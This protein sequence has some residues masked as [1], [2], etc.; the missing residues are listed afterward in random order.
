M[1]SVIFKIALQEATHQLSSLA[2]QPLLEAQILLAHVLQQSR[3][4]LHAWPER[5][6]TEAQLNEYQSVILRRVAGEPIAYIIGERE[7]W[8]LPLSVT[9]DTLIP[10]PE[11][12]L[13]VEFV[14]Q[15]VVE[16][17]AVV[18]DLGTGSGAI[19]LA[20]A[21]E[22]PAW[23]IYAIDCSDKALQV[24]SFNAQQ[25]GLNN[26]SFLLSN[27]CT[28]LPHLMFDVIVSNP[29]YIAETEWDVYAAGL[30]FEPKNALV[31][32]KDGLD[33]IRVIT[34]TAHSFLKPG[35]YL[36]IEHGFEQGAAVRQLF[37]AEGYNDVLSVRDLAGQERITVGRQ[38]IL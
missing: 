30:L 32:G 11:T 1:M 34:Q 15:H 7:F 4:Y 21:H 28:A 23:Q 29:P 22:R 2:E 12:E 36:C 38:P 8:S 9:A 3:T 37:A 27:W 5:F 13:L 20:L 24:A 31:S 10:R 17:N 25:L 19:A 26:V 14:L 35:S 18:A 33:A 6:L 16:P